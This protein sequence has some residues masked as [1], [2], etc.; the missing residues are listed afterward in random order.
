MDLSRDMLFVA[1]LPFFILI[2][3]V[4]SLVVL[5]WIGFF[6]NILVITAIVVIVAVGIP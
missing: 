4:R 5:S 6:G 1:I 2:A 3:T